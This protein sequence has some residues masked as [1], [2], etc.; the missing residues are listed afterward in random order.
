MAEWFDS[1]I[2]DQA[3]VMTWPDVHEPGGQQIRVLGI[4]KIDLRLRDDVWLV[5]RELTAETRRLLTTHA[6]LNATRGP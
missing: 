3:V 2:R 4:P 5:R 1:M 6:S